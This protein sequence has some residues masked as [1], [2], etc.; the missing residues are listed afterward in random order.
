VLEHA[1]A[2]GISRLFVEASE[3]ARPV[4]ERAG[5]IVMRR[6][7]FDVGGVAIHNY[8]MERTL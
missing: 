1:R 8:A 3:N 2:A 4:F 6:R 7:D 5:F